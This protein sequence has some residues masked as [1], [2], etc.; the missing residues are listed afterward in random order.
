MVTGQA[1]VTLGVEEYLSKY[2]KQNVHTA[3]QHMYNDQLQRNA[4]WLFLLLL[5]LN[6]QTMD[7]LPILTLGSCMT[8]SVV[9][10]LVLVARYTDASHVLPIYQVLMT[11]GHA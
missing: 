8:S 3:V 4:P 1:P 10:V 2:S 7:A 9:V 6:I 11:L 5:L